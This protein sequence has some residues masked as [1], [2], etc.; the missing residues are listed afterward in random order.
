[1]YTEIAELDEEGNRQTI[2]NFDDVY[3]VEH[4]QATPDDN[5]RVVVNIREDGEITTERVEGAP[6]IRPPDYDGP[7]GLQII[8]V[9]S[10]NIEVEE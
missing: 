3:F 4:H 2:H 5:E 7:E 9:E 6:L 8:T 10:E 1:M